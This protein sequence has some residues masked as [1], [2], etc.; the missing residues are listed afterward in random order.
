MRQIVFLAILEEYEL[1]KE[2]TRDRLYITAVETLLQSASKVMID[3]ESGNNLLL[4][5]LD[6]LLR[7]AG[8]AVTTLDQSG[9][10]GR[11]DNRSQSSN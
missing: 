3:V 4:L 11:T 8:A 9:T 5:P 10:A 1:A 2:V 6:Q 7:N